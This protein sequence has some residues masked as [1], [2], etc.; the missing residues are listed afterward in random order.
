MPNVTIL[1]LTYNSSAF[2]MEL[3]KSLKDFANGSEILVVDN[4]SDDNTIEKVKGFDSG[5]KIIET[6]KNLGFAKGINLG[7]RNAKGEYLL[8]INPDGLIKNGK[9][10]DMIYVFEKNNK[11]GVVGGKLIDRSGRPEKS[12]GHFFG[13]IETL[14]IVL[15]LDE[16]FG[17]RFSPNRLSRVDF[18]SGGFMMVRSELFKKLNGFDENLFMYVEDME[19]CFR[20]KKAGLET[21]FTPE[22]AITHSGQGSSN[23]SFA[24]YNIYKGILYF[25]KKHK[26]KLEYQIVKI[27]LFTKAFA[28]YFLGKI[29][30]N[31]YYVE[32]YEKTFELFRR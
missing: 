22:V 13:L 19:F 3:L 16:F 6:G 21:Y 4:A 1:I 32:T 2:I 12:A 28:I 14:L 30:H 17:V 31:S 10:S 29:T 11:V 24:I 5:A 27:S 15:G 23:R 25:Y 18:V 9:L 8:F 20:V 26:S 7:A